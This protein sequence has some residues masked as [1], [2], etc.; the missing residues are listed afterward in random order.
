MDLIPS[1]QKSK[2]NM[3]KMKCTRL[4]IEAYVR[5]LKDWGQYSFPSQKEWLSQLQ[6]YLL[7]DGSKKDVARVV[8]HLFSMHQTLNSIP[9]TEKKKVGWG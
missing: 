9:N 8:Q 3:E 4:S 2:I 5:Q 1:M 7:Y 6:E